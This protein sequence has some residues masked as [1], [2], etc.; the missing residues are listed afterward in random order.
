MSWSKLL[1]IVLLIVFP[2]SVNINESNQIYVYELNAK[3][4]ALSMLAVEMPELV[5]AVG[6]IAETIATVT[7]P[8][9]GL[10]VGSAIVVG[11][12]TSKMIDWLKTHDIVDD[13]LNPANTSPQ[14]ITQAL[15][16]PKPDVVAD[17]DKVTTTDIAIPYNLPLATATTDSDAIPLTD[18][19]T[20]F[21]DAVATAE[22]TGTL[23]ENAID[24]AESQ[25]LP[26]VKDFPAIP[27]FPAVKFPDLANETEMLKEAIKGLIAETIANATGQVISDLKLNNLAQVNEYPHWHFEFNLP[28]AN[29]E[30]GNIKTESSQATFTIDIDTS[31][32]KTAISVIRSIIL[33]F[34][35]LFSISLVLNRN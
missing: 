21:S 27:D 15:P 31:K 29:Y 25:A 10:F 7:Q 24:N 35:G 28:T 34:A 9:I 26:T 18:V 8:E 33:M 13:K 11:W 22:Q 4:N 3:A 23:T 17:K 5:E 30:N 16:L 14:A 2:Y 6:N 1:L 19:I 32:Y 20:D 12:A